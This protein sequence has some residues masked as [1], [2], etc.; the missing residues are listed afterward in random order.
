MILQNE[1]LQMKRSILFF[2]LTISVSLYGYGQQ[3]NATVPELL[4]GNGLENV[5]VAAQYLVNAGCIEIPYL[6]NY[7]ADRMLF[8]LREQAGLDTKGSSPY[9]GVGENAY[10]G[11]F[12][13]HYLSAI[14]QAYTG[15]AATAQQ[16]VQLA[17][18]QTW[19]PRPRPAV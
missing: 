10:T 3:T 6:L 14:S 11:H 19:R 12:I 1:R 16:K 9:G 13:G 17:A 4:S 8:R 15:T 2:M 5:D 18:R 7:D